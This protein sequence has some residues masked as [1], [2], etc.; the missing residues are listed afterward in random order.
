MG[1]RLKAAATSAAVLALTSGV[2]HA[3]WGGVY[4][5]PPKAGPARPYSAATLAAPELLKRIRRDDLHG[6]RKVVI[7]FFQVE[8]DTASRAESN[9]AYA[10]VSSAYDLRG[11]SRADMQ[12]MTEALYARFVS[13]L[14]AQGFEVIG[15]AEARAKSP[16]LNKL[17]DTAQPTPYERK[18]NG[19][20]VST[21]VTPASV[22]IYFHQGDPE[23]GGMSGFGSRAHWNQP[24][25]AKELG[26]ALI[27]ARFAVGFV[28]QHA[29]DRAFLGLRSSTARVNSNV[30]LS[31]TPVSTHLWAITPAA[32]TGIVG[33][34]I[35]PVRFVLNNALVLSDGPITSVSDTTTGSM[36]RGD[37]VAGAIGALGVLAGASGGFNSKTRA[38]TVFVDPARYKADVGAALAGV[39]SRF[40]QTL[41]AEMG[42]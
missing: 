29:N 37:A 16:S 42:S 34:P 14:Q 26:A 13:D 36:K 22:P 9:R 39:E 24:A 8:F 17:F 11:L 27:G 2:A 30:D 33:Q 35:E 3:Q 10:S 31:V 19:G 23:L 25:A 5:G 18:T 12:E 4:S 21:F 15:L 6:F 20:S 7:P 32:R 41:K 38:H 28:D 40:V 1:D